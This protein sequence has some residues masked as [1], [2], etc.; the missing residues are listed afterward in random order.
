MDEIVQII[1]KAPRPKIA[2]R[3]GPYLELA[4]PS[5]GST[6]KLEIIN[7]AHDAAS[8]LLG[9]APRSYHGAEATAAR[10]L[11]TVDLSTPADLTNERYLRI[12]IDNTHLEE[13]DCAGTD[14][15]HTTLGQIR[16]KINKAFP[17]LSVADHDGARLILT[18]PT[19]GSASCVSVRSL[20]AQRDAQ[21]ARADSARDLRGRID[22]SERANIRLQIDRGTPVDINCAGLE[23]DK[24]ERVEIVA[25]INKALGAVAAIITERGISVRSPSTGP[26]SGIVFEQPAKDDA[27]FDIFG[28]GPLI[29]RGSGPAVARLTAAPSLSDDGVDLRANYFLSMAVDGGPPVEIDF[30][31][32][33]ADYKELTALPLQK[34]AEHINQAFGGAQILSTDGQHLFLT[35]T[36]SGGVSKLEVLPRETIRKRRFVTRAFVTDEAAREVFGFVTKDSQG[37][38]AVG[39]RLEGTPG[40]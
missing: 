18:S 15:A 27:T 38:S 9:L 14:A 22:L 20:Q 3:H 8:R 29:F 17:G 25:A 32:A 39:A 7:G 31:Q 37:K 10:Y 34:L 13:I 5:T 23:P 35:S 11:G 40:Q 30:R 6:S 26:A 21:P 2:S 1:N 24:T 4:S 28:I 36:R 19:K 12:E 16:D 33:A